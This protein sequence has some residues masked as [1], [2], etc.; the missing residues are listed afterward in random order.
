M[1]AE[2]MGAEKAGRKVEEKGCGGQGKEGPGKGEDGAGVERTAGVKG[3]EKGT[4]G[5]VLV[6]C[7][8]DIKKRSVR[9]SGEQVSGEHTRWRRKTRGAR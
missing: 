6:A 2:R 9:I 1:V 4:R 3:K 8:K 7:K 5:F